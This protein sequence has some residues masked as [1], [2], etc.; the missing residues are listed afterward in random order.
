MGQAASATTPN[1]SNPGGLGAMNKNPIKTAPN[2]ECKRWNDFGRAMFH[3]ENCHGRGGKMPERP[4]LMIV[5]EGETRFCIKCKKVVEGQ[6]RVENL[7]DRRIKEWHAWKDCGVEVTNSP[8]RSGRVM[9]LSKTKSISQ[10]HAE[11]IPKLDKN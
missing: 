8:Y 7:Y 6:Y 11:W 10:L 5:Q 2:V 3:C 9:I 4:F 1:A